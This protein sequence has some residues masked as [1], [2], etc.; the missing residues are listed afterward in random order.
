MAGITNE[1]TKFN[2]VVGSLDT[3]VA[4]LISDFL[5]WPATAT[6]F[7]GLKNRIIQEFEESEGRKVTKLLTELELGD[8]KPSQLLREIRTL[9]GTQVKDDLLKTIFIQRLPV[10]TRSI[11]AT[12]K[13]DLDTLGTM[14]DKLVEF[15]SPG[16]SVCA[17]S[18]QMPSS[19]MIENTGTIR[20]GRFSQLEVQVA[21]L[22]TAINELKTRSRGFRDSPNSSRD[23]S[24]QDRNCSRTPGRFNPNGPLCWYHFKYQHR[25]QKCQTPC[26]FRPS[27]TRILDSP[28]N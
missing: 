5:T 19:H 20:T 1:N 24:S 7:T 13:D 15:S 25:A 18:V 22:T 10:T 12:S 11:L 6:P 27:N 8:K 17:Q 23:S 16:S 2:H 28:S 14:A 3:D 9:A 26:S 21:E 4:E